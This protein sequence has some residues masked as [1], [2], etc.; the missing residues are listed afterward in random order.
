MAQ[1]VN[2]Y[3]VELN[4]GS[5]PVVSLKQIH[6]GDAYA[7]RIGAIVYIDGQPAQLSGTC[8]GMAILENATTVPMTGTVSGNTAYVDLDPA[9]YSVEGQIRVFVKLTTGDVT[10]TLLAAVG[11]VALTETGVIIDPGTI[12]PSISALI[13]EIEEARA[14]IPLDYSEMSAAVTALQALPT[15]TVLY[16]SA[17]NLTDAQK[18]LARGNIGA[19]GQN[20]LAPLFSTSAT[21]TAGQYV[22]YNDVLYRFTADHAAGAWTGTDVAAV[23][24]GRDVFDLE[25]TVEE[26][27]GALID[28]ETVTS[29]FAQYSLWSTQNKRLHTE[30]GYGMYF[31][32]LSGGERIHITV[33][34]NQLFMIFG[35]NETININS[36][37]SDVYYDDVVFN[38]DTLAEYT[39]VNSSYHT[40]AVYVGS[41]SGHTPVVTITQIIFGSIFDKLDKNQ[42]VL[43]A[44]KPLVVGSDGNVV[45][46]E[47]EESIVVDDGF[48]VASENPLQ[49]KVITNEIGSFRSQVAVTITT[50]D[51]GLY[52]ASSQLKSE[53]KYKSHFFHLGDGETVKIEAENAPIFAIIGFSANLDLENLTTPLT[54]DELIYRKDSPNTNEVYLYNN[55][56]NYKTLVLYTGK[57]GTTVTVTVAVNKPS[58]FHSY[59][60]Q[61]TANVGSPVIV[62]G[63]GMIDG[64]WNTFYQL[65]YDTDYS[66]YQWVDL[67]Y[68]QLLEQVYEPLR[69]EMPYYVSREVI[70]RDQSDTYDIYAYTFEPD[71]YE[72]VIYLQSGVHPYEALG[73]VTLARLMQKIAHSKSTDEMGAYLR[74]NC[75]IVVVPVVNVWGV[76]QSL[77]SRTNKNSANID[78]NTD[79]MTLSQA[80]NIAITTMFATLNQSEPVS[81]AFDLHTTRNNSFGDYMGTFWSDCEN[82][83]IGLQ[84]LYTLARKNATQRS[85]EYLTQYNLAP[86][87]LNILYAGNSTADTTYAYWWKTLNVSGSTVEHADIVWTPTRYTAKAA[88]KCLENYVLQI[89]NHATM[90]FVKT[91]GG[92]TS[93]YWD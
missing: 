20:D 49:N 59:F 48:D 17:Q 78:L 79:V 89:I 21:Y 53:S 90:K 47:K 32:N 65:A 35:I 56:K 23:V 88:E 10:C 38:D 15:D 18:D 84:T 70:G 76:M 9:C 25:S 67:T 45:P 41:L 4:N 68:S 77:N 7:N 31:F 69:S 5:V 28:T 52:S 92:K 6:Y 29:V 61:G 40:I 87:Q 58:N 93:E 60:Y 26:M 39:F 51:Y 3:K 85:E 64:N 24:F 1:F 8:S 73:Y 57:A 62:N 86:T 2:L 16:G 75:K 83:Q 55:N 91:Y 44:G 33:S 74:Y 42:G 63:D 71:R 27:Q 36:L 80:E 12:I 19:A 13:A 54:Y 30:N 14:S 50:A 22:Y 37:P 81:F 72:Q 46:G 34:D 82:R 66:W 11:N 43:N